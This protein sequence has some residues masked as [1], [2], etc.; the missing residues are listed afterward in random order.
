MSGLTG[1]IY[2]APPGTT[3][4]NTHASITANAAAGRLA[5]M[6]IAEVAGTTAT[7]KVQGALDLPQ[8][9]DANANWF[10]MPYIL[11]STDTL[12]QAAIVRTSLGADL[13]W[14]ALSQI[15]FFRRI[16]LVVS[17]NTG[18]T[19]RGELYQQLTF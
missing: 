14:L 19:Y 5:V 18:Q 2:L 1:P 3:G 17:A 11:P 8:V 16:R 6:Y 13:I 7:W 4:N 9:T 10:D 15:R 12:S